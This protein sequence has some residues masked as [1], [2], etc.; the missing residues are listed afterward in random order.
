[1]PEAR[2]DVLCIGNA[3]V[4][5]IA[6]ATTQFLTDEGLV[7]GSMR[8]IDAE[9]AERLYAAYGAGAS[10]QRRLGG[11]HRRR[12]SPRSAAEPASSARSRRTSSANFYRHDLT[13]RR[14]RISP[15][16]RRTSARRPRAR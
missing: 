12:A 15:P 1:M 9:E 5:V 2:L 10:G 4:D 7:K 14:G 3:I 11:E 8:L 6:N 13:C 16:R